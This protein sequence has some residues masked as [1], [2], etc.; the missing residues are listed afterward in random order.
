MHYLVFIIVVLPLLMG[1]IV[2]T[3]D[4]MGTPGPSSS[5]DDTALHQLAGTLPR[6]PADLSVSGKMP[7]AEPFTRTVAA[8]D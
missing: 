5:P 7:E 6:V 2:I 4:Y 3:A 8:R 1:G